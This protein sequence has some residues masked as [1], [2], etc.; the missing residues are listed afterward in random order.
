MKQA[1]HQKKHNITEKTPSNSK[2]NED[3]KT[4]NNK[5]VYGLKAGFVNKPER[6]K[7]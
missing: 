3:N 7:R 5:G 2:N 1:N 6:V 4:T